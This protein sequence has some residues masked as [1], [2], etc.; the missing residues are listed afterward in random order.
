MTCMARRFERGLYT[1]RLVIS[2][3]VALFLYAEYLHIL[4][5]MKYFNSSSAR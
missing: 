3:T 5:F 1:Y 2:V 4:E